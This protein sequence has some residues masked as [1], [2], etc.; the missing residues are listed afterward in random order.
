[1]DILCGLRLRKPGLHRVQ[2]RF[3]VDIDQDGVVRHIHFED[4]VSKVAEQYPRALVAAQLQQAREML[5]TPQ[6][7]I[8]APGPIRGNA[9][10]TALRGDKCG[11]QWTQ[12]VRS[13]QRHIA[14]QE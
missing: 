2:S 6:H 3:W 1:M 9:N 14:E 5:R 4:L 12:M 7:G 10:A 13:D 11:E 8:P